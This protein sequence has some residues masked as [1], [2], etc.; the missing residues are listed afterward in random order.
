MRARLR[1]ITAWSALTALCL[2]LAC[3]AEPDDSTELGPA[4]SMSSD[5]ASADQPLAHAANRRGT[6]QEAIH[7]RTLSPAQVRESL[8]DA[9]FDASAVEH[10]RIGTTKALSSM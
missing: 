7:L 9:D 10:G 4:L 3:G 5:E 8:L 2:T 1:S 6:L